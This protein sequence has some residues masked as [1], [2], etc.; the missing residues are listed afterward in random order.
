MLAIFRVCFLISISCAV[1]AQEV[2]LM[3]STMGTSASGIANL[4]TGSISINHTIG[5]SSN[6]NHFSAGQLHLLQ[7]FQHPFLFAGTNFNFRTVSISI[8]PNPS[9]GILSIRWQNDVSDDIVWMDVIDMH[10]KIVVKH[11]I[12]RK[13]QEVQFDAS[14]L[15]K[16]TYILQLRSIKG[17]FA[18]HKLILI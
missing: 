17:D 14:S 16:A 8:Y 13:N 4:V 18:T 6:I 7:G 9:Q 10:G 15:P 11:L 2:K 5:Q 1:A 12:N 3:K